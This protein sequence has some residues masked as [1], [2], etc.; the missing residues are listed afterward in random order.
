[1]Q[2]TN[3]LIS[4]KQEELAAHLVS[5]KGRTV[6]SVA[7]SLV[8][9]LM[10]PWPLFLF[11]CG[12]LVVFA[13]FGWVAYWLA[14]SQ[15]GKRWHQMALLSLDFAWIAFIA[16][17]P[18]PFAEDGYASY[19]AVRAGAFMTFFVLLAGLAFLYQPRL[20]LWGGVSAAIA[21]SVGVYLLAQKPGT[22][23]SVLSGDN[24]ESH[25][26]NSANPQFIDLN[27]RA[28]EVSI[29]LVVALL[30]AMAVYRA[31][32]MAL[33]QVELA[34]EKSNLARYFPAHTAEKLAANSNLFA[35]P[36]EHQAAVL[37]ADLVGFTRW[38]QN[39]PPRETISVVQ[40]VLA[41][42]T[43][44]VFRNQGTLDKFTG[45]GLMATFGTPERGP[46]DAT[47]AL[48]AAIEM[49]EVFKRWQQTEGRETAS[50]LDLSIGVHYG[51]V[52]VGDVGTADRLEF[53]VLGNTVNVASRLESATREIGCHCLVSAEL[54][55]AS[56]EEGA[57][58]ETALSPH[59]S[60]EHAIKLKGVDRLQ[61][62][63]AVGD[64]SNA[65]PSVSDQR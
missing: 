52:V 65:P 23:V 53:A 39:R 35:K 41:L 50:E 36:S 4:F 38:A 15:S 11:Y 18:N 27:A 33:R 46:K 34:K 20:V 59:L 16:V 3:D 48:S 64:K 37:F 1:M 17:Y 32:N 45:D 25:L 19:V 60:Q 62:A 5:A 44:V 51:L 30:L 56:K 6:A 43:D 9:A 29:M 12:G 13:A 47:N 10:V 28:W 57:L 21:W 49:N 63:F 31:R 61:K 54:V 40:D 2:V 22:V 42:L 55:E 58:P 24:L 8:A 26:A 7:L 14:R